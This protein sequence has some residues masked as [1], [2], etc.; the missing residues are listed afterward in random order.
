MPKSIISTSE[1]NGADELGK[2]V[3][4]IITERI[5]EKLEA[6]TV[7]WR[8][9]WAAGGRPCNLVSGHDYS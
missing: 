3:Y 9:P 4:E 5:L 1:G 6:G 2:S 8:K 7:P